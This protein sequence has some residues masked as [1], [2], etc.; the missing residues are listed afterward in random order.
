M[1]IEMPAEVRWLIPIVVGDSWPEG[2]ETALQRLGEVWKQA[3]TDVD[4][5]MREA[6]D[7]VKQA[8]SH[9]DG[10]AAEAFKAYWEK[11]VKGE[12]ATLPKMKDVSEKLATACR[13]CAMQIEYAKLSIIIALVILAIQIA[14]MLASAVASFGASTA[15]IV[16]AQ[17]ATRAGVQIVFR[18]LVQRLMQQV[19]RNLIGKLALQVGIEV[20][21]SVATDLAVQGIQLAKGTR[22]SIDTSM[23]LDA[24]KSGLISGVVGAGVGAGMGKAFGEGLGDS[25]GRSIGRNV[26][27]EAIIGAGSAL[28]EGALSEEG[29]KGS[30][31]LF[32]ATSGAVSGS[33]SGAK[34]GIEG[35]NAHIDV[36]TAGDMPSAPRPDTAPRP[37]AP[38]AAPSSTP[39]PTAPSTAPSAPDAD[40]PPRRSSDATNTSYA[41]PPVEQPQHR[42]TPDATPTSSAPPSA[43]SQPQGFQQSPAQSAP[44]AHSAGSAP[45]APRSMQ[46]GGFSP[47]SAGQGLSPNS[48]PPSS[49]A[50]PPSAGGPPVSGPA[51]TAGSHSPPASTP[52][53]SSAPGGHA[54]PTPGGP[55][56]GNAGPAGPTAGSSPGPTSGG[57]GPAHTA[58]SGPVVGNPTPSGPGTGSSGP[59]NPAPSGP[60]SGGLPH[61]SP[62]PSSPGT[63]GPGPAHSA[64]GG[65]TPGGP[66]PGGL[67][68]AHSAAGGPVPGGLPHGGPTPST[69]GP[70]NHAP[71]GPL[72][73]GPLLHSAPGGAAPHGPAAGGPMPPAGLLGPSQ[74]QSGPPTSQPRPP[75]GDAVHQAGM[76]TPFAPPNRGQN[77]APPSSRGHN[78]G[79]PPYQPA[80]SSPQHNAPA[81]HQQA[82]PA[83]RQDPR[84]VRQAPPAHMQAPPPRTA[85][86][87]PAHRTPDQAPRHR[88]PDPGSSP[89]HAPP[90]AAA[91]TSHRDSDATPQQH[92]QQHTAPHGTPP[93]SDQ[94]DTPPRRTPQ[95]E[96]ARQNSPVKLPDRFAHLQDHARHTAAGLSLHPR[97]AFNKAVWSTANR[98][99]PD[100]HRYTVDLHGSSDRAEVNGQRLSAKDVADIIR[101]SGDWDGEQPIRLISCQT[102]TSKD[103]FAAQLSHELGVDVIAPTKD[104]WVDDNGNIFASSSHHDGNA[105]ARIHSPGWPPNGGWTTFKPDGTSTSHNSS[106]PPGHVPTWGHD[107][108]QAAPKSYRRN[109]GEP[110]WGNDPHYLQNQ[111]RQHGYGYHP[112]AAPGESFGP[113]GSRT[114]EPQ[115]MVYAGRDRQGNPIYRPA[116]VPPTPAH[117]P[118]PPRQAPPQQQHQNQQPRPS[119]GLP[120][121]AVGMD[122]QGRPIDR[123]GRVLG[124]PMPAHQQMAPPQRG[125]MPPQ[126]RHDMAP[127][128]RHDM[129]PQQRHDVA[130]QQRQ[131]VVH[132]R[133]DLGQQRQDVG[134]QQQRPDPQP[135]RTPERFDANKAWEDFQ[136]RNAT[137]EWAK[138]HNIDLLVAENINK[139][140]ELGPDGKFPPPEESPAD[141]PQQ[142]P[143]QRPTHM[144]TKD[145]IERDLAMQS[146][147]TKDTDYEGMQGYD[148]EPG[149]KN[150]PR[151]LTLDTPHDFVAQRY[152]HLAG[153]TFTYNGQ[154][155][156]WKKPQSVKEM[157]SFRR[158]PLP[159]FHADGSGEG[160]VAKGHDTK[161]T[162]LSG[163]IGGATGTPAKSATKSPEHA[164]QRKDGTIP[165]AGSEASN[166]LVAEGKIVELPN[167]LR[168]MDFWVS[169]IYAEHVIDVDATVRHYDGE[170][171]SGHGESED[172]HLGVPPENI[173][174]RWRQICLF[175]AD[176]TLFQA[177][178]ANEPPVMNPLFKYAHL[179]QDAE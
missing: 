170:K 138:T 124:P 5:A 128:Q 171:T 33:V 105:L 113:R 175:N 158:D 35:L 164:M 76:A 58:P 177:H 71:A 155:V 87:S 121:N 123:Q 14:M 10:E 136:R 28:V 72:A 37:D 130:P 160:F 132:Q 117:N 166:R 91:P 89:H 85:P 146:G 17:L 104:A 69:P 4:D 88:M 174:R 52:A 48:S 109:A 120:P 83:H 40:T 162:E 131:N 122:R 68:A 112:P 167:G 26:G 137:E 84:P 108:P 6:E 32:G 24:A 38:L 27:E 70:G 178:M 22:D 161:I 43:P 12:E 74:N 54:G 90:V 144:T 102:G 97:D 153:S 49:G 62:T 179:V 107:T 168:R 133:Q 163:H 79:P 63:G 149:T 80:H 3:A 77:D 9:M 51:P 67:G 148:F 119:R 31:V 47:S 50:H 46:A 110:P 99:A 111:Q 141:Q 103:G 134:Q 56:P 21:T 139:G 165:G 20:A 115:P 59:G 95:E 11:F 81:Q 78:D 30:D 151:G 2:D 45:A 159:G 1:G 125:D 118:P 106:S 60:V 41:A 73:G 127:P 154:P 172:L 75:V 7:A 36:P 16:P 13:N 42:A 18:Q 61:S 29:I 156:I 143:I 93:P 100:P 114:D 150:L 65:P 39:P 66:T 23:T 152:P 142:D 173:R 86:D 126:Q 94:A 135:A 98:V 92:H 15:G 82:P 169:E 147:L 64:P 96:F 129:A 53:P 55:T 19:G 101:S 44:A 157:Q 25:I 145:M 176:G 8:T 34:S 57:P 140:K 116:Y